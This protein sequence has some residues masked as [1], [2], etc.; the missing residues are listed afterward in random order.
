MSS[1][2]A[3]PLTFL[4]RLVLPSNTP[5]SLVFATDP[6]NLSVSPLLAT[7]AKMASRKSFICHTCEPPTEGAP[8]PVLSTRKRASCSFAPETQNL[9]PKDEKQMLLSANLAANDLGPA[10]EIGRAHV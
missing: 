3:A 4:L 10:N 2:R 1:R 5:L 6:K 8:S 9:Q 7:L